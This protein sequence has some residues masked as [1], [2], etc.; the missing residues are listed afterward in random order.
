MRL[1]TSEMIPPI[2]L[3]ISVITGTAG[4]S[5]SVSPAPTS[6]RIWKYPESSPMRAPRSPWAAV[7][8]LSRVDWNGARFATRVEASE[9]RPE[10]FPAR[11]EITSTPEERAGKSVLMKKFPTASRTGR[12]LAPTSS[13]KLPQATPILSVMLAEASPVPPTWDSTSFI[14]AFWAFK[15]SPCCTHCLI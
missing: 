6:W 13:W 15:T 12:S 5:R 3:K 14:M 9:P 4:W 2:V 8:M 1:I 7:A 11:F 10:K